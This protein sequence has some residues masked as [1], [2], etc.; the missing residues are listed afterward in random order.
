MKVK[1]KQ[2]V[3]YN[4]AG[5][6]LEMVFPHDFDWKDHLR[7]FEPFYLGVNTNM[8][9]VCR[10][11]LI[12]DSPL[13]V[14]DDAQLLSDLSQVWG[15]RF[16]F[17]QEGENYRTIIRNEAKK[18]SWTMKSS[19]DFSDSTIYLL[20]LNLSAGEII[21]WFTMVAFGQAA[22]MHR[23][24]LI[25]ASVVSLEGKAYAFLGKSGTGKS[26]HSLLWLEYFKGSELLNDDNPIVRIES[27]GEVNVYGTPWSG[28]TSCYKNAKFKMHAFVRLHQAQ[29]NE[30]IEKKG[31]SAF[32][33]LLPSC[34]A[35]RWNQMLFNEMNTTIQ[36]IVQ[37]VR[38]GALSCLPN[39]EAALLCYQK[40]A[41]K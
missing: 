24:V 5:L 19:M 16:C 3:I 10:V 31:L 17:Y 6:N 27:S 20:P 29:Q 30:F 28:K 2:K 7:N 41:E 12:M 15:D 40:T 21:S 38:C 36:Y 23:A 9:S 13:E 18:G 11:E 34:T 14:G 37:K 1:K 8:P 4:I 33:S 22:L 32:L 35:L 26:T 25:H 39:E